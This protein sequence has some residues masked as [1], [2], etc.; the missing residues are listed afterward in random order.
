MG[1]F[2]IAKN[3]RAHTGSRTNSLK[4][5]QNCPRCSYSRFFG[6]D[7]FIFVMNKKLQYGFLMLACFRVFACRK[8]LVTTAVLSNPKNQRKHDRQKPKQCDPLQFCIHF[9]SLVQDKENMK[10]IT[11]KQCDPLQFCIQFHSLVQ[12]KGV[13]QFLGIAT[14]FMSADL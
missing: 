11:Q 14:W 10:E 7:E 13:P 1:T 12:D 5:L 2:S 9:H 8:A 6:Y 3:L 4:I